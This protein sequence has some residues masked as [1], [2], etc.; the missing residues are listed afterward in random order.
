VSEALNTRERAR[1]ET[2][3]G[4]ARSILENDLANVAAGRFG[5]DTGGTLADEVDLRL[6]ASSMAARREIVAIVMH[7]TSE[8]L[9]Q[10]TAVARLVREAV[11]THLNRLVAIR[12]AEAIGLLPPS[13]AQG[14]SS[15]GFRDLLETTPL[16][17]SDDTG[18]YWTYLQLCGDELAGDVPTLFD[19]RNPLLALV[20]SPGALDDLVGLLANPATAGL[21]TAPDCL[22][23]VYQFF[24]TSDERRGMREE[25]AAPRDSR[26]LAVRNQF[27]T[28]RY[29]VDFLVQ[30][31]LGRRLMEGDPASPLLDNLPLLI[32]PPTEKREPV[33]LG[34]ASVLD[35]ACGSGHFLLAS[36]DVLERAWHH[37]GV[38]ADD[39]APSIVRSLWGIDIDPR[40][41]QVAAAAVIFRA[42]RS[43]PSAEL[44][45]PNII[46]ARSLSIA[47]TGLNEVLGALA[48]NQRHLIEHLTEALADAP[49]LGS[50]LKAEQSL[51]A[52]VQAVA[53]G[54]PALPGTLADSLSD[55][56]VQAAEDELLAN[57]R[58]IADSTTASP[59]ERL[60][61]AEAD[62]A[63]RF[64]QALQHRY[65]AVLMNP[66]FGEP[67]PQ[68]KPYL[69]RAFA[70]APGSTPLEA[71]FVLRGQE[72][73]KPQGLVGAITSRAGM[74]LSTYES[75]RDRALLGGR[76][77]TLVDLGYGIMQQAMVE[78]AAYVT[79]Q[80]R[81]STS[82]IFIR[83]L[84]ES[85]RATAISDISGKL[86][87]GG[88]DNRV[89]RVQLADLEALPRKTLAYWI[90][91]WA[92]SM[93]RE[94]PSVEA[95]IA[96][97]RVGGWP[98]DNFRLIR[99]WWEP[100]MRS[101]QPPRWV[102][103]AKGGTYAPF[104]AEPHLRLAWDDSRGTFFGFQGRKGRPTPIPEN[105]TYYFRPGLTWSTR[106][107]SNF[108]VRVLPS[109][110][111]F[112]HKGPGI[113][114]RDS[115]QQL[116]LLSWLNSRYARVF[117]EA[118]VAA[119]EEVQS[120][121]ASRSYEAG[122]VQRIPWPGSRL[123]PSDITTLS[124]NAAEI[125][126]VLQAA[127]SSD[128]T[129]LLFIR[130]AVWPDKV[131]FQ[132][133][134]ER[135]VVE[136]EERALTILSLTWDSDLTLTR[137]L[138][139]DSILESELSEE[140]G[141]H[142]QSYGV[143][144]QGAA[145]DVVRSLY[146][147][148]MDALVDSVVERR[149][150]GR[151][152]STMSHY[153]DRRLELLAHTAACGPMQIIEERRRQALLPPGEP[154]G[155][156]KELISYL[157]GATIGRWD[158]R[159]GSDPSRIESPPG[160]FDQLP[161][162]P[163]SM[164][165]PKAEVADYAIELPPGGILLDQPGAEWDIEERAIRAAAM[166][167]GDADSAMTDALSALNRPSLRDYLRRDFFKDHLSRYSKSRR[168]APIY[169]P[170]YIPS[171]RWGVWVYAPTLSRETLFAIARAASDRLDA[172][173]SEIRRLE[174]EHDAGGAGRSIRD[175]A[176][177][178]ELQERLAAELRRFSQEAN[179]V[180]ELGWEP[181]LDDGIILCAAPLAGLFPAWKDAAVA[182]REIKAGKYPWAHVSR[183]AAQ[184]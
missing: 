177:A 139:V 10:A 158:I 16:L 183:W 126:K 93:F 109:G 108:A 35:P 159:I 88:T 28:P 78:A 123:G 80:P 59:A 34:E 122:I 130:P 25:S 72:M 36:Y 81:K 173:D 162:R 79:G 64:V 146:G 133:A 73:L 92:R 26:E 102:T 50:L 99:L 2:L 114:A 97:V 13:L 6:D 39:A 96:E 87:A 161:V 5:I 58:A 137:A 141:P 136:D 84:R 118:Q 143:G 17:A 11:F 70:S 47:A 107:A 135:R 124:S 106:T 27:F 155:S 103:Y 54:G 119:G 176:N 94:L 151:Y 105:V 71:C 48:A 69:K 110:S 77:R 63:V 145:A 83:L 20:P 178:L 32:D 33:D 150:G 153:A 61:A 154:E 168:K 180:A 138:G 40:C 45:R 140:V 131:N 148:P 121:S 3:V 86:R 169:W 8:G 52:E 1:L 85:D 30:N 156:S 29:V 74:F 56:A 179:R 101:E 82:A 100:T 23:W 90:S 125:I 157:V 67:V 4:R 184:L 117:I 76:T 65:D 37:L 66:P 91:P 49:I 57:L 181:E 44:P 98:G 164:L 174:R 172:A 111:V 144:D 160:A 112:G 18:G 75:W 15:Q 132:R 167:F 116:T 43:C 55:E 166:L 175:V 104:Y 149:G 7:L 152:L 12:I 95:A 31:S 120:G 22:G 42:R 19:P 60:F 115:S 163:V 128:E 38:S 147:L 46:C 68:T 182:R 129:S 134:V 113:F 21:W 24:N 62:D 127:A 9:Q 89:F 165:E 53:I 14:R 41:V 142:P 51:T 171:D 170:L